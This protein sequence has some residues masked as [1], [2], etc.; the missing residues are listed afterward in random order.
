MNMSCTIPGNNIKVFA[1]A[2]HSL[3]K[4]GEE[5][6]IEQLDD[7]L[8]LKTVN[9]SRSAFASFQFHPKFFIQYLCDYHSNGDNLNSA[10]DEPLRCK[11]S[12][13]SCLNIFK[14]VATIEKTVQK[15]KIML[16]VKDDRLM[17]KLHCKHGIIKTH[18]LAFIECEMLQAVFDVDDCEN[19]LIASSRLLCDAVLNFQNNQEEVTLEV[20]K[21]KISFKNHVDEPDPKKHMRTELNLLPDEFDECKIANNTNITFCLKELRAILLF[22]EAT[23]LPVK[24]YF[25]TYGKPIIYSIQSERLFE[26]NFVLATRDETEDNP[27]SQALSNSKKANHTKGKQSKLSAHSSKTSS[28]KNKGPDREAANNMPTSCQMDADDSFNDDSIFVEWDEFTVNEPG[29]VSTPNISRYAH[30]APTE[31]SPSSK[32]KVNSHKKAS[33]H[34]SQEES[35]SPIIAVQ[36][37]PKPNLHVSKQNNDDSEDDV[38]PGTPPSKK[39]SM[40]IPSRLPFIS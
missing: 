1:R 16:N 27:C 5:L 9:S 3:A 26:A 36:F 23:S 18:N 38:I 17:F 4:I 10:K 31:S 30:Q 14:S 25:D 37:I 12:I 6:Y 13:K 40:K 24:L 15:C 19:L 39:K 29:D 20:S 21:E 34:E 35:S 22:A 28:G 2:I 33:E 11:I 7:G 32:Q 8:Y